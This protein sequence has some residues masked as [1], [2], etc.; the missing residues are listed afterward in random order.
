MVGLPYPNPSDPELQ[1]RLRFLDRSPAPHAAANPGTAPHARSDAGLIASSAPRSREH[2]QN[3]CM[4]AVNQCIG[5]AI[6]HQRDYAAILLL[7]ARYVA[8]LGPG[9]SRAGV[10]AKLPAWIQDSL[11]A[12]TGFG[13]AQGRLIRFFKSMAAQ[14]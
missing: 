9:A 5:R 11:S 4:K 12:A 2:Y 10:A 14:P 3:L 6:R 7:D 13:D 1:E 8:A